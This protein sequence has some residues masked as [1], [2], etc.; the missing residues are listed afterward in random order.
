MACIGGVL[1][2]TTLAGDDASGVNRYHICNN[3]LSLIVPL[4]VFWVVWDWGGPFFYCPAP[5]NAIGFF[6]ASLHVRM[7][8]KGN[9][10][11]SYIMYIYQYVFM[12]TH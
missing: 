4:F 10:V 12:L 9:L 3:S 6:I 11:V 5:Q 1:L 8:P 7:P 2:L